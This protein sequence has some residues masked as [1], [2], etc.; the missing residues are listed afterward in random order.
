MKKFLIN[1]L[2]LLAILAAIM[3]F[4]FFAPTWV[5]NGLVITLLLAILI[6]LGT[7]ISKMGDNEKKP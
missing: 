3:V 4:S 2:T 7:L 5:A 6:V 1:T